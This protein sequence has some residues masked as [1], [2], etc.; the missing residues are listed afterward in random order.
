MTS[1][2]SDAIASVTDGCTVANACLQAGQ[3]F[4]I[5]AGTAEVK[6]IEAALDAS[7][8]GRPRPV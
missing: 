3:N 4:N 6:G 8:A 7:L 5:N 2:T 1:R